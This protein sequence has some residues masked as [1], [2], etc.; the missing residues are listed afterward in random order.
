MRTV[1]VPV[2]VLAIKLSDPLYFMYHNSV[3]IY[4]A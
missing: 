3:H 1:Y 2:C 4:V